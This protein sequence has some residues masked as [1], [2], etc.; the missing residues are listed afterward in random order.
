MP[1]RPRTSLLEEESVTFAA[2]LIRFESV[3]T[4]DPATIG[5]GETRAARYVQERLEEL[6]IPTVFVE[7]AP[8][9]GSVVA[10]L[11]GSDPHAGALVLHA[12]LDV[13][14]ADAEGWTHPPFGG[15]IDDGMLYGRGAVDMKDFAG[16][17]LAVAREFARRGRVPRRD[18]VFAFLADEESGGA[19]GAGWLVD[20]RP[21]L[22]A[23]A[24]QALGE[25]GGFSVPYGDRRAYLLATGEKG[26]ATASVVTRGASGHASLPHRD[27]AVVRLVETVARISG[28]SAPSTRSRT[29]DALL[30]AFAEETGRPFTDRTLSS[31][32]GSLG[33]VGRL[34]A[35]SLHS[36]VAPTMLRA[37]EKGNVIPS[38][39]RAH[40]DIRTLPGEEKRLRNTLR[41]LAWPGATV[42]WHDGPPAIESPDDAPL[43]RVIAEAIA[44]EDPDAVVLPYLL[45]ASTDNKHFAKL[46]IDGYGFVPL[47]V[48]T[49][50]DVYAQFH[51]VDER[52]PVS[53]L[54]FSARV[55]A[56]ILQR[57]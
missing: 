23:G 9:R 42:E 41:T 6:G 34:I 11:H 54:H 39:A 10:R 3:N 14:P 21:E 37:G 31:D 45:P 22:F 24:T 8:G 46:G 18:L 25:V 4:G 29:T 51:A 5:D 12:H 38:E 35:A 47:R 20:N 17:L 48:P 56:E 1:T 19:H 33:F 44:A 32:L 30:Q 43:T 13:V 7:P 26:V 36:T 50:F 53:S 55:T 27:D 16:V 2:N 28:Y 57:A 49:D 40:L 52:V 15:V